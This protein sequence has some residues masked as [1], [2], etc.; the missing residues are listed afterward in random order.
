MII[1]SRDGHL[2]A[3]SLTAGQIQPRGKVPLQSHWIQEVVPKVGYGHPRLAHAKRGIAVL[4]ARQRRIS[5]ALTTG[6]THVRWPASP[7]WWTG[8][9]STHV[10]RPCASAHARW[11]HNVHLAINEL[12]VQTKPLDARSAH[13]RCQT[14]ALHTMWKRI[15]GSF[16]SVYNPLLYPRHN[17]LGRFLPRPRRAS[18]TGTEHGVAHCR[19]M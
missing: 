17:C 15:H 6:V 12:N 10:T 5:G 8:Q 11:R 2:V 9:A 1:I 4:R 3:S 18:M 19:R 14:A 16:H 13:Q 7:M